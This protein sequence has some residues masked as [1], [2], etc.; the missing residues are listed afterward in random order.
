MVKEFPVMCWSAVVLSILHKYSSSIFKI[1]QP[2]L[3][4]SIFIYLSIY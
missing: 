2:K 3:Y 4:F 1:V